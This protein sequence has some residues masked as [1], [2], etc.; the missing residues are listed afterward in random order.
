MAKLCFRYSVM[1]SGKSLNLI[2]AVHSMRS[3]GIIVEVMKPTLD[4]RS[5]DIRSR[6]LPSM[7]I[8]S[9]PIFPE[10]DIF[11]M[12]SDMETKPSW[13]YV[14]EAQFLSAAQV[15]Q[16]A[17]IADDLD[18]SVICYGLRTDFRTHLFEGSKRLFEIADTFEELKTSCS[19][20][21]K[22]AVNARIGSD[23]QIITEG[24]QIDCGAEDKYTTMCRKCF[25]EKIGKWDK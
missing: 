20:G 11:Q 13:I 12:I 15:D 2:A 24:A 22:A 17:R 9:T 25:R 3:K 18:I 4:S 19:C 8:A 23:G 5:T 10:S 16:L 1:N 21:R 6:A 7:P 14:D